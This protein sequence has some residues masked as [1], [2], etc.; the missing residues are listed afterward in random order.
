MLDGGDTQLPRRRYGFIWLGALYDARLSGSRAALPAAARNPS[1][2]LDSWD[3]RSALQKLAGRPGVTDESCLPYSDVTSDTP[4]CQYR[5][6][7]L[8]IAS[9]RWRGGPPVLVD[10]MRAHDMQA[11]WGML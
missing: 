6:G 8:L 7:A 11:A 9:C 10:G 4:L 3:L 5:C 1:L 2:C